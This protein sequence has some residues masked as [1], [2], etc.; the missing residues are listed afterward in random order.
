MEVD[1]LIEQAQQ[2]QTRASQTADYRALQRRLL[3]L[4]P[5]V[6]LWYEDQYAASSERIRGYALAADGAYDALVDTVI[7]H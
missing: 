2:A 3:Q 7:V 4:L 5:Y 6:P 1:R